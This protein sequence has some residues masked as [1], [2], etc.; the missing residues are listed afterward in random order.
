MSDYII[1]NRIFSV[2]KTQ[3][4]WWGVKLNS[5]N[6]DYGASLSI[7]GFRRYVSINLPRWLVPPHRRMVKAKYWDAATVARL[8]R[9]WY[10]DETRREFGVTFYQDSVSVHYGVQ[11]DCSPGD[12]LL[13]WPLPWMHWNHVEDRML[14]LDGKVCVTIPAAT[15][16]DAKKALE[17][18]APAMRFQFTDYDGTRVGATVQMEEFEFSRGKGWWRWLDRITARKTGRRYSIVLDQE[19]GPKKGSW[20]GGMLGCNGQALPNELHDAAFR[21]WASEQYKVTEVT[22]LA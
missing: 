17:A 5:G 19:S 21:R 4:A 10:W 15:D 20:K 13:H 12:K 3:P 2:S 6:E 7:I 18:S 16:Y 9:D 11:P 1:R 8:G 22:R 14:D